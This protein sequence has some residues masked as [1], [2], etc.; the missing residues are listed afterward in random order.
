MI[1]KLPIAAVALLACSVET[2][3]LEITFTS[4]STDFNRAI[5]IDYY[6]PTNEVITS[7]NYASGSPHNFELVSADG[8]KTTFSSI[9]GLTDEVKIATARSVSKGGY[10][11]GDD[12]A[13]GTFYSGTG[14]VGELLKVEADL[15]ETYISTSA[16]GLF[17]GSMYVDRTGVFDGDLIAVSTTGKVVRVDHNDVVTE[18]ASIGTHLEGLLVVP[19]I[20]TWGD[21]AGKI[22][23]GAEGSGAMYAIDK[24]GIVTTYAGIGV[25]IEDIDL[26]DANENFFG[27]NFSTGQL[28]GADAG[29]WTDAVGKILLTQEFGGLS[30]LF[31]M[32]WSGGGIVIEAITKG[33]G[34]ATVG[35]WEHVTFAPSG[36]S[37]IPPVPAPAALWVLLTGLLGLH[38]ST[39]TR[40]NAA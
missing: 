6:E 19:D 39:K 18:I 28:L 26:I 31:T 4:I 27:V 5:G 7:V 22:I 32:E 20:P 24:H 10:S 14:T 25:N 3:A 30:G 16:T 12:I 23:T 9:S 40:A 38:L 1:K 15:T 36:I 11:D 34:S 21:L 37:E 35:Q 8:S 2:L 33:A 17:R 29:Q 13:A